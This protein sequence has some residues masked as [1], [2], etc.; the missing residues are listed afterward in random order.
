MTTLRKCL[1][2]VLILAIGTTIALAQDRDREGRE[3]GLGWATFNG[4][5]S[6]IATNGDQILLRHGSD[7]GFYLL[8][9]NDN[10]TLY[11]N[12]DTNN[13]CQ[14][15]WSPG[16]MIATNPS[17]W[18]IDGIGDI[19]G[20]GQDELIMRTS[21]TFEQG[22]KTKS[23]IKTLFYTDNGSGK[24]ATT[25]PVAFN[26]ATLWTV[27]GV[28][29]F[30]TASVGA[31]STNANQILIR[32]G[33]DGGFYL[34]YLN[35]N[36][37]LYWDAGNTNDPCWTSWS[38]GSMIATNASS[39]VVDA[40]GDVNGDGQDEVIVRSTN[41]FEQGGKTKSN[42]KVLFFTDNGSGTLKTTQP[43]EFGQAVTWS[44]EG[45]GRFNP[46]VVGAASSEAEQML[47]RHNT[48]GG[49][50]LL[51]FNDNGTLYWNGSDTNDVCWT[52]WSA[53]S[54]FATNA[55]TYSIQG[56]GDVND[57]DLDDL[58]VRSS[59]TYEQGGKTKS[60][61]RVLFFNDNGSGTL[62][63]TQPTDFGFATFWTIEGL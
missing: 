5:G 4:G 12:S 7:Y 29:N 18:D 63:S 23:Q 35:D 45:L 32:H 49:Y 17:V 50:Y 38:P 43:A 33:T 3:S 6:G 21:T 56:I 24:L 41:T 19:D 2:V 26:L 47:L 51:Y 10:G 31:T 15:S 40:V 1:G 13:I 48:D 62:K 30:N 27:E 8:Y 25:Q 20:D 59:A 28:G 22:G 9:I 42:R 16:S 39:W 44:I 55:P 11:W 37:T 52:S 61:T 60:K 58:V 46:G 14:T 57:D 54:V 36:G 53:G 34:L